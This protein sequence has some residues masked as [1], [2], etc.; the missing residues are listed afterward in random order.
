[1]VQRLVTLNLVYRP[2]DSDKSGAKLITKKMFLHKTLVITRG[3][4]PEQF[5]FSTNMNSTP[6]SHGPQSLAFEGAKISRTPGVSVLMAAGLPPQ[7]QTTIQAAPGH[8][9]SRAGDA[10][11]DRNGSRSG[12]GLTLQRPL[13]VK[14]TRG[15][16]RRARP[17]CEAVQAEACQQPVRRNGNPSRPN[18][19]RHCTARAAAKP[20]AKLTVAQ[21]NMH[22]SKGSTAS[23]QRHL[24]QL[25]P[26]T[27][28]LIQEPWHIRGDVKGLNSPDRTLFVAKVPAGTVPRAVISCTKDLN[29]IFV[30]DVSSKDLAVIQVTFRIPGQGKKLV[31]VASAYLPGDEP[32]PQEALDKLA[33]FCKLTS[34]E[35]ILGGDVNAHHDIWGSTDTN[36]R[37]L[38]LLDVLV[39]HNWQVLNKGNVP[40]FVTANR[41][42]VL[43]ITIC[44]PDLT[45]LVQGWAVSD[46]QMLSD[47]RMIEFC[48]T[49]AQTELRW[50]RNIKTTNWTTYVNMLANGLPEVTYPT[51]EHEVETYSQQLTQCMTDALN[52]S[53]PLRRSTGRR[54]PPWWNFK[55]RGE[56]V[57]LKDLSSRA[58]KLFLQSRLEADWLAAKAAARLYSSAIQRA[59]RQTWRSFCQDVKSIPE[60]GRLAR[61]LRSGPKASMGLLRKPNGQSTTTPEE[62]LK[63]LLEVHFPNCK[64]GGVPEESGHNPTPQCRRLIAK[65]VTEHTVGG[66]VRSLSPY[67]SP[68]P[69]GIYPVLLQKGLVLLVPHLVELYRASL[70][71]GYHPKGWRL[72]RVV[73]IPKLNKASYDLAK[74]WRPISLTSFLLKVGEKLVD[75]YLKR[76]YL[77]EYPLHVNQHAYQAGKSTETALHSLLT[78][79]QDALDSNHYAL[80]CLLDI[81]GAFDNA[82]FEDIRRALQKRG[83]APVLLNWV[84]NLMKQRSVL[85]TAG[86]ASCSALTTQ[87]T[88]QGGVLSA[89]FY[90]LVADELLCQLND[91]R[92]FTIGYSDDTTILLRG[93]DLGTLCEMMQLALNMVSRWCITARMTV[94]AEKT[95]LM[96]FTRRYKVNGWK[97]MRLNG[98][99]LQSVP[100]VKYLGLYLDPKLL[101]NEH[102]L[103]KSGAAVRALWQCKQAVRSTWGVSAKLTK[104]IYEAVVKPLLVYGCL[105]WAEAL[106]KQKPLQQINKVQRLGCLMITSALRT[107]PLQTLEVLSGVLPLDLYIKYRATSTAYRL[108]AL[109]LGPRRGHSLTGYRRYFKEESSLE[110]D[111]GCDVC[112]AW[113][114]PT[115][116]YSII[117]SQM[118]IE[119]KERYIGCYTFS[120]IC[121]RETD[122]DRVFGALW[123]TSG[124]LRVYELPTHCSSWQAEQ[125][126]LIQL[127]KLLMTEEKSTVRI[128]LSNVAYCMGLQKYKV[129]TA[130]LKLLLRSLNTVGSRHN[131]VVSYADATDV[132][133]NILKEMICKCH[134]NAETTTAEK[135]SVGILLDKAKMHFLGRVWEKQQIRWASDRGNRQSHRFIGTVLPREPEIV[136]LMGITRPQLFATV[137]MLTGHNTLNRH[138]SVMKVID[139]GTCDQCDS[140]ELET[141]EHFLCRCKKFTRLRREIFGYEEI[142]PR[143][144]GDNWPM[145]LHFVQHSNRLEIPL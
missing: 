10:L 143:M 95:Q 24:D 28:G 134:S 79:V 34:S 117:G 30:S 65:V 92:W 107:A 84:T 101:W 87:G 103:K 35:L 135:V 8:H 73:F 48:L 130:Q 54:A 109:G 72:A 9:Q 122:A 40:T 20:R 105:F 82:Q 96:L 91:Q 53:C 23:I 37:G 110:C 14:P 46:E 26:M 59:K 1:M 18:A 88:A 89:L 124:L 133:L 51:C 129:A 140:G 29:P 77:V 49:K 60:S 68:G 83:I 47:H 80:A 2:Y 81:Q 78:T 112:P 12:L 111:H 113:F 85:A 145:L 64:V 108:K 41:R 27:I 114:T 63:H 116:R 142:E 128:S 127:C 131:L 106:R 121:P 97:P 19:R 13:S 93:P 21:L 58:Y 123:T 17:G 7:V 126:A 33:A 39:Q 32:I 45:R 31:T 36:A 119:V 42:E 71:F 138:L 144:A 102:I 76:Q 90:V 94:S 22:H 125:Y 104:W 44:S 55:T 56:L 52:Q 70:L 4:C 132:S 99:L 100:L 115:P 25:G 139:A 61:I 136:W 62:T 6:S 67:K 86:T 75:R 3:Q 74:S 137:G 5:F 141:S 15:Q 50:T 66:A 11:A 43:D 118:L 57:R 120:A 98:V 16:L 38:T 69:D